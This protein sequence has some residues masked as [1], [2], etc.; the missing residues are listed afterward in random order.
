MINWYDVIFD[1]GES[2]CFAKHAQGTKIFPVN[3]A[4]IWAEYYSLNPIHLTIDNEFTHEK[5]IMGKGRRADA[6]VTTYRNF[7]VEIDD[8]PA[9]EQ[10]LFINS[11]KLPYTMVTFSGG[12][13]YHFVISLETSLTE[14]KTYDFLVRWLYNAVGVNDR[15]CKNPSRLTRL[16]G[17]TRT[18]NG[19]PIAIQELIYLGTRIPLA[20]LMAWLNQFPQ[21]MP[22]QYVPRTQPTESVEF[23]YANLHPL[24]KR[25]LREGAEQGKWNDSLFKAAANMAD[26]GVE[27]EQ[28]IELCEQITGYLDRSDLSTIQSA[29]NA[30]Q[31]QQPDLI[32]N[33]IGKSKI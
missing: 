31:R 7:L 30:A 1:S 11:L 33:F 9:A 21:C 23:N 12:K 8:M 6:N 29:F 28:I 10:Q 25:F 19:I 27:Y 16:P 4:P 5:Y 14:R 22:P 13:S 26:Y 18:K 32:N 20:N 2:T 17:A 15:A 3:K 24:T